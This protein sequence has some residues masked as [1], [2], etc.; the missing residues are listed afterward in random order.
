MQADR[1]AAV[2]ASCLLGLL[3]PQELQ[4]LQ[5]SLAS[6]AHLHVSLA[7]TAGQPLAQLRP[8]PPVCRLLR[9]SA[10]REPESLC[11]FARVRQR[12]ALSESKAPVFGQC[13]LWDLQVAAVPLRAYDTWLATVVCGRVLRAAAPAGDRLQGELSSLRVDPSE[14]Q[15]AL[16][17]TPVVAEPDFRA[18]VAHVE[19]AAQTAAWSRHGWASSGR[20]G[21]SRRRIA[22]W[23][24]WVRLRPR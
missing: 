9:R 20:A 21:L 3:A 12:Q 19:V 16:Q 5:D 11:I 23:E 6:V 2:D 13:P 4:A 15:A 14:L 8:V 17:E 24:R 7:T 18:A 10:C 1:T 22:G